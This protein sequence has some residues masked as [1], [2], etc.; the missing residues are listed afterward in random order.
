MS[1]DIEYWLDRILELVKS[2]DVDFADARAQRRAYELVVVDNGKL[3]EYSI[4]RSEGIGLRVIVDGFQAYSSVSRLDEQYL[5]EA[6]GAA[7][8]AARALK[9]TRSEKVK[10]ADYPSVKDEVK[11]AWVKDPFEY[12]LREKLDL[13]LTMNKTA[14]EVKGITSAVT[15]LGAQRDL[16]IVANTEGSWVKV[17]TVMVGASHASVA[18]EAGNLEVVSDQRSRV[19]GWEFIDG[20]SSGLVEMAK[21]LSE[22]ASRV[23][24][25][26]H[27]KAGV[28]DVVLEPEIVGLFLHEALGHASEGDLISSGGS[29][30]EGKE[31]TRLA[32]DYV[33]I[34][35]DGLVEGGYYVPYDDEGVRKVQVKIVD[36]G[37]L[38]GVLTSREEAAKLG[39]EPTGNARVMDYSKPVIVRQTNYYMLP[40]DYSFEE[41][42]SEVREGLYITHKGGGGGQVDPAAGTFTFKVGVIWSIRNGELAEPLRGVNVS[43]S[44]LDILANVVAVGRDLKVVTSVFGGCGKEG[45]LVRV[46][47]GG[48]HVRVK[49]LT[50]GGE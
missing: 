43:G 10:L 1:S 8:K 47:D 49:R 37:I 38:K 28:Y 35:D 34:V 16:R 20:V 32:P 5:K 6:V 9:R 4:T 12:D 11:S 19:S 25:A 23:V 7:V 17:E 18:Q 30:L 14:L 45:Q 33:T 26:R 46:G 29:V 42:I 21:E 24:R 22:L 36:A 15:R 31:G 13:A 39:R 48:P 2:Y 44:I 41:M 3:R 40:G 27:P 50:V